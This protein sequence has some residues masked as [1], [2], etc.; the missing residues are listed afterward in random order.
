MKLE[1][2]VSWIEAKKEGIKIESQKPHIY[3]YCNY[4]LI[5]PEHKDFGEFSVCVLPSAEPKSGIPFH[6]TK[7]NLSHLVN[8]S[9]RIIFGSVEQLSHAGIDSD[10]E[11]DDLRP[12]ID[13]RITF[14]LENSERNVL[15]GDYVSW[16]KIGDVVEFGPSLPTEDYNIIVANRFYYTEA[17]D[18]VRLLEVSDCEKSLQDYVEL[19]T[20]QKMKGNLDVF[21]FF[22]FPRQQMSTH[23]IRDFLKISNEV[24][25]RVF[26]DRNIYNFAAPKKESDYYKLMRIDMGQSVEDNVNRL[27]NVVYDFLEEYTPLRRSMDI[28]KIFTT[29]YIKEFKELLREHIPEQNIQ[30][31]YPGRFFDEVLFEWKG[32]PLNPDYEAKR[33]IDPDGNIQKITDLNNVDQEMNKQYFDAGLDILKGMLF[34]RRGVL[35]DDRHMEAL[36]KES[37]EIHL[38]AQKAF[39]KGDTEKGQKL[40][41]DYGEFGDLLHSY[42]LHTRRE[43]AE[44]WGLIEFTGHDSLD[45]T[46]SEQYDENSS[47]EL[48]RFKDGLHQ[49]AQEYLQPSRTTHTI[50]R[51]VRNMTV[52]TEELSEANIQMYEWDKTINTKP[53]HNKTKC[54]LF[55]EAN[56]AM[57]LHE[58]SNPYTFFLVTDNG[59][60]QAVVIGAKMKDTTY[61]DVAVINGVESASNIVKRSD[62]SKAIEDM[63]Q[64]YARDIGA[65]AVVY[66]TDPLNT[67]PGHFL[68]HIEA[69][70][71]DLNLSHIGEVDYDF[72][73]GDR[74]LETNLQDNHYVIDIS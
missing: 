60:K 43:I 16:D 61:G 57:L 38:S 7:P 69:P 29:P 28:P 72:L 59:D 54:C 46:F 40:I 47:G 55:A 23:E 11:Y 51:I 49:F 67:A 24:L 62:V 42:A 15:V 64:Q 45:F 35:K 34:G 74:W 20:E 58:V 44:E 5:R 9:D 73:P 50:D 36:K 12:T 31:L 32:T 19:F 53:S 1:D 66:N 41:E 26:F 2:I 65:N 8:V 33:L 17:S 48:L 27:N 37:H 18:R 70:I 21:N 39:R 68:K 30:E 25:E 14:L 3:N 71:R 22:N 4:G 52:R 13:T 10:L 56:E 6:A 63:V